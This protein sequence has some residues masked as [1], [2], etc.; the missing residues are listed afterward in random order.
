[1]NGARELLP[2]FD[3][4]LLMQYTAL[5]LRAGP[6]ILPVSLVREAPRRS[7]AL[8]GCPG[9]IESIPCLR[10]PGGTASAA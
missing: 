9:S 2:V 6:G 5:S 3:V 8:Q 7:P 10:G 1:M 4:P